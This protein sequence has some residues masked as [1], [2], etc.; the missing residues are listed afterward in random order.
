VPHYS[1]IR[2]KDVTKEVEFSRKNT[3]FTNDAMSHR[4]G[5]LVISLGRCGVR[6]EQNA[7]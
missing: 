5:K 3:I 6:F 2:E 4:R 1:S 7:N